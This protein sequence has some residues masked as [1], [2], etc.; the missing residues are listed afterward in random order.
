[1]F[2]C[3]LLYMC[4]SQVLDMNMQTLQNFHAI[5]AQAFI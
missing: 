5:L 3:T 4:H 2:S 1:M